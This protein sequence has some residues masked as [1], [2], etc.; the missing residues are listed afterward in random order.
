MAAKP[1]LGAD[2]AGASR[3]AIEAVTGVTELVEAVHMNVL[4]KAIGT[5]AVKP[6][7]GVTAFVYRSVKGVTRLVG[8]GIDAV[9]GRLVPVLGEPAAWAGRDALLAAL[10]GVL[11]DRLAATGNPLA[12]AMALRPRGEASGRVLVLAHGLCMNDAQWLRDG[13][14]HGAMLARERGYT[15]VYLHYNSG[16]HISQN[17]RDFAQ[18]LQDLVDGWPVP[19]QELVIVGHSMGGLLARSACHYGAEA[20]HGWLA[21]LSKLVFLGTPHHGAPLERGGNWVH[22]LTDL[23][24]YS[25]PF[26][27]LAKIRSAG[28]TD[29]R[30]GSVLDDDWD[31]HDRFAHG[32]ALP[33]MP[34][35]PATVKCFAVAATIGKREGDLADRLLA[36]DGLVPLRSGLAEHADPARTLKLERHVVYQTN[37]MQLLSSPEVAGRL[38]AW[39]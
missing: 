29:L 30:H 16:R 10:N 1:S 3:L 37:H 31:G 28:I 34:T 6:V 24:V 14:D 2:L 35:L 5:P 12:I 25:A 19:V 18:Q 33:Q 36:G 26:S 15:P 9:L 11:G 32:V 20:R 22:L 39:L 8:G 13:V 7:V 38:L 21:H 27:R 17:G 4:N 23:S